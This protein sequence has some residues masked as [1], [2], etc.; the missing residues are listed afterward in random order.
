MAMNTASVGA[1]PLVGCA[2][3]SGLFDLRP[4]ARTSIGEAVRLQEAEAAALSPLD[5]IATAGWLL[6]GV[7][8]AE[9][10]G[11]IEQTAAYVKHRQVCGDDASMLLLPDLNHY[12][13]LLDLARE[14]G[15]LLS[16]IEARVAD[17][18]RPAP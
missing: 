1:P 2:P 10:P 5:K 13:V 14:D 3:L 17:A 7:G 9:T 12:T 16:G 6:A 4:I 8:G 18:A 15:P 11:F